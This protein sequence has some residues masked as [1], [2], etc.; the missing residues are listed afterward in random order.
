M[1]V[2]RQHVVALLDLDGGRVLCDAGGLLPALDD[3]WPDHRAL[4]AAVGDPGALPLAPPV[5]EDD[6][7]VVDVLEWSGGP[8]AEGLSWR[9]LADAVRAWPAAVADRV[10]LRVD[11]LSAAEGTDDGREAWFVPGWADGVDA[12]VEDR[13]AATRRARGGPRELVRAWG[14]SA[15]VRYPLEGGGDVWLKATC[16]HFAAE[17]VLTAA[18]AGI[19]ATVAPGLLPDVVA[20]DADRAWMLLEAFPESDDDP[21]PAQVAAVAAA[22][23]RLQVAALDELDRLVAAGLPERGRDVTVA[24]LH[25]VV[26]NGVER[27][28]RTPAQ[29]AAATAALPRLVAQVDALHDTGLPLTLVHGDLHL[30]NLTWRD[31]RPLVFDWTDACLA[32]PFL[33][34][35]HLAHSARH[36]LGAE[37][38]DAVRSAYLGV[39]RAA[40]P[41]ADLDAAWAASEV[42]DP[43]FTLVTYDQIYRGQPDWARWELGG[44]SVDILDRLATAPADP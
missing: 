36:H 8:V 3:A 20:V 39:W 17:P 40:C 6:G 16:R 4:C 13:L 19:A 15:L 38:A 26:A 21:T 7:T 43:V 34:G 2:P 29:Q 10:T 28:D 35:Q 27:A 41:D 22:H 25:E 5:R 1:P 23:A 44:I 31:G 32:H 18:V 30:G 33:D 37:A 11:E 9:G 12:W 42:A 24:G 14:L